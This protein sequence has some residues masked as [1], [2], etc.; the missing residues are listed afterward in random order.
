MNQEQNH[1][2][3]LRQKLLDD[4]YAGA[5]SGLGAMILDADRVRRA[6]PEELE[7][8]ARQYGLR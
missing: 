1:T 6:G 4:L 3:E 8:I 2:E 5:C 7:Q